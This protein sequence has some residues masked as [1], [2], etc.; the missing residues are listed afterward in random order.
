MVLIIITVLLTIQ[1]SYPSLWLIFFFLASALVILQCGDGDCI[2]AVLAVVG[3]LKD[4]SAGIGTM[5]QP[6]RE[7]VDERS[8]TE[9]E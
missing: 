5:L 4:M 7:M 9:I 6:L 3:F 1:Y 8:F 2:N